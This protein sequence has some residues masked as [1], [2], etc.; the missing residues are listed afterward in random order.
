MVARKGKGLLRTV[1]KGWHGRNVLQ[2]LKDEK[3]GHTEVSA[4]GSL[5]WAFTECTLKA[6]SNLSHISFLFNLAQHV[7]FVTCLACT[8]VPKGHNVIVLGG[9]SG[10]Y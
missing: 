8:C 6:G 1:R 9:A 7:H 5:V 4:I 10:I 3:R 2:T